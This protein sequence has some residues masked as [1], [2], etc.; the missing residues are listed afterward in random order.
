MAKT[1]RNK[2]LSMAMVLADLKVAEWAIKEA[3]A[4]ETGKG[5]AKYIKAQSAYHLQQAAEKLIKLQLYSSRLKLN[6]AKIHNHSITALIQYSGTIGMALNIPQYVVNNA[7]AI[8]DWEA[9]GR[10]DLHIIVRIDS[11]KKAQ[12]EIR[13]WYDELYAAGYR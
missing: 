10:Y 11:L 5:Q 7:K 1:I 8:T 13:Q 12:K 9:Q 6:Y 4:G 2:D 3:E